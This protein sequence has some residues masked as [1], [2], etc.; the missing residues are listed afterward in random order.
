MITETTINTTATPVAID[1]KELIDK[2]AARMTQANQ[3]RGDASN[4]KQRDAARD[5][6]NDI[7]MG[8]ELLANMD[9][10]AA[11]AL[12]RDYG[13]VE[14]QGQ[15]P[16]FLLEPDQAVEQMAAV[17][18]NALKAVQ[19]A[20][21]KAKKSKAKKEDGNEIRHVGPVVGVE[22][23]FLKGRTAAQSGAAKQNAT[24]NSVDHGGTT[25]A[26]AAPATLLQGRFVRDASGIYRR[27]GET[28]DALADEDLKIRF[29]DKQI[30]AFEA[31]VE[32]AKAKGWQTIEVT[33]TDVFKAEA[34]FHAKAAGL[35]VLGYEP[36]EKDRA[37]L[38]QHAA[39]V[40]EKAGVAVNAP[41]A[42]TA[43]PDATHSSKEAIDFLQKSGRGELSVNTQR[44]SYTG[45]VLHETKQHVVQDA[46]KGAA[47]I[48]SKAALDVD[49]RV[50][51]T[52]SL[53][54]G[55]SIRLQYKDGKAAGQSVENERGGKGR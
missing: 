44:G 29:I 25:H 9:R 42:L 17:E 5:E 43:V 41:V 8:L 30:D 52:S 33:G 7:V 34:W 36:N 23:A 3:R 47:L 18:E 51:L 13:P 40:P 50:M 38:V 10:N 54:T 46:G 35:H 53:A 32:L 11:N 28:R 19:P 14:L 55:K 49:T 4:P 22:N 31:G 6:N 20:S 26:D 39:T 45:K 48:H 1:K 2:L 16:S 37:R 27:A 21:S 15:T 24:N 12:W